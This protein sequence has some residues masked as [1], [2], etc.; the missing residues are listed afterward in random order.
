MDDNGFDWYCALCG[1]PFRGLRL[2][3][4]DRVTIFTYD[5]S[6]ITQEETNWTQKMYILGYNNAAPGRSK[7]GR[8]SPFA[9]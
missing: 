9:R 7:Y 6:V 8:L 4:S 5:R 3:N 2:A 1:G